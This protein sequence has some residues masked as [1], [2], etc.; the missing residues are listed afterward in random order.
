MTQTL[1]KQLKKQFVL[2]EMAKQREPKTLAEAIL[3]SLMSFLLIK[4]KIGPLE[5]GSVMNK[6]LNRILGLN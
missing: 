6:A 3:N 4:D 1:V 2:P 5:A